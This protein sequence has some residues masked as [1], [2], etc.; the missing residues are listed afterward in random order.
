MTASSQLLTVFCK[1]R[2]FNVPVTILLME[3]EF[4]NIAEFDTQLAK[5][6]L[7]DF[8]SSTV[9]FATRLVRECVLGERHIV[10]RE[11]VAQTIQALAEAVNENKGGEL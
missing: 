9:N 7:K 10:L 6:V 2:K 3:A 5:F 8:K 4:I 1:Q 11:Q